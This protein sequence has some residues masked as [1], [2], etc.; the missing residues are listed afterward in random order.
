MYKEIITKI[1]TG[2]KLTDTEIFDLIA[3]INRDE[4]TNVQLAGFQV[5]LL[6]KGTS[7]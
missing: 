4:I 1:T 2:Q 7:L 6:M 5:G 3:A